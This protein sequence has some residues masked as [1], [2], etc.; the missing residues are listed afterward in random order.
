M[1]NAISS[2]SGGNPNFR[3]VSDEFNGVVGL[4]LQ[5]GSFTERAQFSRCL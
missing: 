1:A 2:P 5:I 3:T 4:K